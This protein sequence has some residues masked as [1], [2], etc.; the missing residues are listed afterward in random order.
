MGINNDAS[1]DR[2]VS[3]AIC[4]ASEQMI[5]TIENEPG[6]IL[7]GEAQPGDGEKTLKEIRSWLFGRRRTDGHKDSSTNK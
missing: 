7:E 1:I 3:K 6:L 5:G 4:Q 2:R